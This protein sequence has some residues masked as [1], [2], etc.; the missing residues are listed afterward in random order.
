MK[1]IFLGALMTIIIIG[2]AF[3]GVT[4][5]EG[6]TGSVTIAVD[7]EAGQIGVETIQWGNPSFDYASGIT[8][9]DKT[10][11]KKATTIIITGNINSTDIKTLVAQNQ[12]NNKWSINTLDH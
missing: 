6:P 2:N 5:T 8:E 4:V 9:D 3:A 1:R 11:I 10:K 12:K 7:G